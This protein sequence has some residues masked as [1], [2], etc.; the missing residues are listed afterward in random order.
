MAPWMALVLPG[1][2]G[3]EGGAHGGKGKGLLS[4]SR[5]DGNGMP[6]ANRPT[7]VRG[8]EWPTCCPCWMR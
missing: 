6:L 1:K 4:H 2:G 8:D 3:G 7:P 5:P